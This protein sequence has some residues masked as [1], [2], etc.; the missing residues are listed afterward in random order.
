MFKVLVPANDVMVICY[1]SKKL[2]TIAYN[3]LPPENRTSI[4]EQYVKGAFLLDPFYIAARKKELSGFYHLC[5]IAPERFEQSEYNCSYFERTGLSDECG[6][7]IQYN[8]GGDKFIIVS[9]GQIDTKQKFSQQDLDNLKAITPLVESLVKYH[10][11]SNES[12]NDMQMDTR[13][14]L[15]TAL[16]AFGTS[17]LTNRENQTIQMILHGYANRAIAERLDI[18]IETVKLHRKNAY[19][20]LDLG[21]QGELFNLFINSLMN[22]E[23]YTGGDPLVAYFELAKPSA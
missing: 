5:D 18:S 4:V 20:K 3:D 12:D 11:Q 14:Q 19:A 6:Y 1:P 17:F 13:A 15:E 9:L 7:L 2:P 10:W 16:E 23:N 8:G 21:T 22:I